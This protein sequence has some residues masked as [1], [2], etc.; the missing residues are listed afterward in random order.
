M[1]NTSMDD[2]PPPCDDGSESDPSEEEQHSDI[3]LGTIWWNS[4]LSRAAAQD[5]LK[6]EEFCKTALACH[7]AQDVIYMSMEW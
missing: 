7:F 5:C 1:S 3:V 6:E 2:V 4:S